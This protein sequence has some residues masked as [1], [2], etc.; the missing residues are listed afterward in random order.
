MFPVN[1][2]FLREEIWASSFKAICPSKREKLFP[3][4]SH[5]PPTLIDIHE[6]F[7]LC[8]P[9]HLKSGGSVP[10]V[11]SSPTFPSPPLALISSLPVPLGLNDILEKVGLSQLVGISDHQNQGFWKSRD[12]LYF[13]FI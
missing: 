3:K 13:L 11:F 6:K 7:A 9:C 5:L 2:I 10:E 8:P 12:L 4:T 1:E